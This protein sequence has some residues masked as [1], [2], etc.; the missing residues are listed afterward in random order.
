MRRQRKMK[1]YGASE[2]REI[3]QHLLHLRVGTAL[4]C[5]WARRMQR[6]VRW[7]RIMGRIWHGRYGSR[8]EAE[9]RGDS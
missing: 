5:A 7:G 9:D 1:P 2:N 6:G 3:N 4:I 8:G